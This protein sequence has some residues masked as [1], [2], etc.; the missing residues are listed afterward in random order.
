MIENNAKVE[1]IMFVVATSCPC[2]KNAWKGD[3]RK[4]PE[5]TNCYK[6]QDKDSWATQSMKWSLE[7]NKSLPLHIY[8]RLTTS[9]IFRQ[10]ILKACGGHVTKTSQDQCHRHRTKAIDSKLGFRLNR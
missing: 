10:K 2:E 4:A 6:A 8:T 3:V 5:R 1:I 9:A 7:R